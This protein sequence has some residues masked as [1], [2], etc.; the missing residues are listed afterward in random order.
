VGA[1]YHAVAEEGVQARDI[2]T[3]IGRGL[4]VPVISIAPEQAQEHFGFLGFF[5][6]RDAHVSS[7]QTRAK[8]GWNP[9]GPSLLTDLG[10]M[11]YSES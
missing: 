6:G 11:R 5:V 9:T 4:S 10:N 7:A 8:L 3:A 1:R 2:A